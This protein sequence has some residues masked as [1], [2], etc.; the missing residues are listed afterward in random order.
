MFY[1]K[2]MLTKKM[3]KVISKVGEILEVEYMHLG[4]R[5]QLWLD[6]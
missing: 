3:P 5:K 4:L 2:V 6:Y 1:Y